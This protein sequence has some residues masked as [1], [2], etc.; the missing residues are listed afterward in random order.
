[1]RFVSNPGIYIPHE[2]RRTVDLASVPLASF[3]RRGAAL[4]IDFL[5][6][7][8]LWIPLKIGI[9]Y[10]IEHSL[11]IS[12]QAHMLQLG[13]GH[14]SVKYEPEQ[15]LDLLWTCCLV[16]YFGISLR[17]TNGFTLGKRLMRIR[18]VSLTHDRIGAWQALERTLGYGASLLEGGFGFFQYFLYPNHVCAHDRLAETIVISLPQ[19]EENETEKKDKTQLSMSPK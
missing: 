11:H 1:M 2:S 9:P 19:I 12:E 15:T 5:V 16:I 13:H 6:F 8:L 17:I 3:P 14:I 18:V 4:A 7:A 10:F